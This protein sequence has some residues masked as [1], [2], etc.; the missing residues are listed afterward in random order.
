[1]SYPRHI[2]NLPPTLDPRPKSR[3]DRGMKVTLF[4]LFVALLMVGCGR[5]YQDSEGNPVTIE[6][7]LHTEYYE[8]GQKFWEGTFKDGKEDGVFTGWHENGQIKWEGSYKDGKIYGVMI[9]YNEDGTVRER[10]TFK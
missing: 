5:E 6:D 4:T 7:G 10:R 2:S 8:N 3:L 1:M 9:R